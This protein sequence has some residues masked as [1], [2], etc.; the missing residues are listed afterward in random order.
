MFEGGEAAERLSSVAE[1][2]H[3]MSPATGEQSV[4]LIGKVLSWWV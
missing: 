3:G 4:A 1:V 2:R